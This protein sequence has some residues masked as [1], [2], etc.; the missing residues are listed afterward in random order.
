[1]TASVPWSAFS[2]PAQIRRAAVAV[3]R[4]ANTVAG[5]NVSDTKFDALETSDLPA[6]IVE[7]RQD[8]APRT[9]SA[10]P[11][12][13]VTATLR[14][15]LI[16]IGTDHAA[17]M[18]QWDVGQQQILD[19][20]FT[21]AVFCGLCGPVHTVNTTVAMDRSSD[22]YRMQ[23]THEIAY[24]NIEENYTTSPNSAL[25][26]AAGNFGQPLGVPNQTNP[27]SAPLTAVSVSQIAQTTNAQGQPET[28]TLTSEII[29][30][31]G[32]PPLT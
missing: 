26:F 6:M 13:T 4:A 5:N 7:S 3:L 30:L 29:P 31:T 9:I 10:V 23:L 21:D 11:A 8:R 32:A 22:G 17:L 20:L 28:E 16:L 2:R 25:S 24:S 14:V 27:I 18:D 12:F 1:M 19:A 15:H